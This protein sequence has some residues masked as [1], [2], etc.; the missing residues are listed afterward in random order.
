MAV[1]LVSEDDP[2][3]LRVIS[4]WLG[5]N[6]HEVCEARNGR[7]ALERLRAGGVDLL[8]TDMNMPAMTGLELLDAARNEG[9][10]PGGVIMLTS[11]CDQREIAEQIGVFGGVIHPKPFSPSRLLQ[12][13]EGKLTSPASGKG[14]DG[15]SVHG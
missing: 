5:R 9:A 1:I 11:R 3:I 13:V 14:P 8:I 4:L 2:H 10:L 12:L 6:G 7:D 15:K